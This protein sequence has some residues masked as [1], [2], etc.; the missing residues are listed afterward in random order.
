MK[1]KG[2]GLVE[3]A[4]IVP[5]LMALSIAIIY[6]GALFM[7]Y[8]QYNNAARDAA[9]DI[10]LQSGSDTDAAKLRN[11]IVAKLNGTGDESTLAKAKY[12]TPMT[13]LYNATWSAQFYKDATPQ[14]NASGATDVKVTINLH[15]DKQ[16]GGLLAEWGVLPSN[17][18]PIVFRMALEK[19]MRY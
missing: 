3:F 16:A 8:T 10:S 19:S 5:F 14:N 6:L 18:K 17:L 1:E 13:S 4:I 12:A 9:R 2:Q 7:D 15:L 11:D